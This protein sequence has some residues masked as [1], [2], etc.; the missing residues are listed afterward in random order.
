MAKVYGTSTAR[1]S[2][3]TRAQLVERLA[4]TPA[5]I[6]ELSLHTRPTKEKDSRAKA[7][8]GQSVEVDA[9][10]SRIL[11]QLVSDAIE[12]HIDQHQLGI[13]TYAERQ[14]RETLVRLAGEYRMSP[15]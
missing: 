8:D 4:V 15:G 2:R 12:G 7:F 5:Q 14:E 13:T 10:S 9:M 3:R 1:R 11:R 6:E